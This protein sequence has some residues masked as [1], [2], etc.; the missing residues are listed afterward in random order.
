MLGAL[1]AWAAEPDFLREVRPILSQHC[2]QCHGPDENARKAGLRLDERDAALQPLKRG[3]AAIVP[4]SPDASTLVQR[5]FTSD[6]DDVMPPPSIKRPL[7]DRKKDV[8]RR[9]IA[10]GAEYQ[11][12]WA[13]APPVQVAL[14]LVKRT[15]WPRNGIDHFVLERFEQR[16]LAPSPPADR[17]VLIRRASL[18]LT[19]LPPTIAEADAFANDL[20]PDAYERLVERLLA[21]P[22][23]G[24]RWARRWMDLARYAD[25]NGFEKD[26]PRSI[27]LWR[28]WLIRALNADLPFDQFTIEQLA[29]DLLPDATVD[30]RVAT[31]FHRNTMLNEEGGIDP[32]EYRFY[33]VVDRLNTTGTTW[34]GLT[35]GCAQ[36]HTHKYDPVTQR[37]YYAMMAFLNN[38]DEPV[39]AVPTAPIT[40][41]RT[42]LEARIA[43][44]EAELPAR[45]P[46]ELRW[47]WETPTPTVTTADGIAARVSPD[48]SVWVEQPTSEKNTY[49]LTLDT[50]LTNFT[51]LRLEVLPDD[52]LPRRGPG[53][54]ESGNFVLSELEVFAAPPDASAEP[55]L[56]ELVS[57]EADYS[58]SGFGVARAIDGKRDSGWAIAGSGDWNVQRTASFG[59]KQ[60]LHQPSGT[61]VTVRLVQEFGGRHVLGR[62]RLSLAEELPDPRPI[63]VRRLEH[64]DRQFMAWVERERPRAA[65]W[66][67]LRPL[68]AR[69]SVPV[70]SI[71][72]DGGV[73]VTSD[74]TKSDTYDLTYRTEFEGITALR[75]EVLPDDRLPQ[76][77]PGRVEY[78]GPV[79]DFFLS[80]FALTVNGEPVRF[81]RATSS[82][83]KDGQQDAAKAVDDD[84]QS[85]WSVDG[86]QGRRHTAVFTLAAPLTTADELTVRMLFEKYYAAGLG[87]FRL[88]ATTQSGG[89]EASALPDDLLA[90]VARSPATWTEPERT[91]L[92]AYYC[93]VAPELAA[94]REPIEKLRREMPAY[95]TTLVMRERPPENP[96]ATFVHHRGEFLQPRERVEPGIPSVL[97]GLPPDAPRNR[98]GFARWLVSRENPLTARVVVNR[99]WAAFFGRGLVATLGDFGFQGELPSHPE[100]LDWLAVEFMNQ[101]WSLKGLHRLIMTSATYRQAATVTPRLLELDPENQWLARAPRLRLDAEQVRDTALLAAGLLSGKLGGPSVFPPQI[102]SITKEGTYGP[103]DWKVSVGEDRYRRGLYT[104]AKRTAPYA[105]F[106]TFDGPS[107]ETCVA[108]REVSNTPLQALTLLNDQVFHEAAQVLGRTTAAQP[109]GDRERAAFVLRRCLTRTPDAG[110]LEQVVQFY[111]AQ[112][113]RLA[114]GELAAAELAGSTEGDAVAAA[115]WTAVARVVL[116][117]DEMVTRN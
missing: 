2:F 107:G 95:P 16:G 8:L 14:P 68:T 4:G 106:L 67:L 98:L 3:R 52:R 39:L 103:L 26:R 41:R 116:N 87:R 90:L 30:Q 37:E 104:F 60:P 51:R 18:D 96:R 9:W 56:L 79:G 48:G 66:T 80:T 94:E 63:E 10:A 44:L 34:L 47:R 99:E 83:A 36:C 12:H 15:D 91:R 27:W 7:N 114:R 62:F 38:A 29:G 53:W 50:G 89:T 5:V 46:P 35:V 40:A 55:Q 100:L 59:V 61:R 71:E 75:L 22:H 57:P 86:G 108:R 82:Y 49:T 13:F 72:A 64:R 105:A 32:L 20:A 85:G 23:Y 54:S 78:E 112:R 31:G 11:P 84:P 1:G 109:G 65:T 58:Q 19:G 110:E 17:H 77:G 97:P 113:E 93:R 42:E 24:E 76:R 92:L 70:L 25:T 33:S 6:E 74:Q 102:E 117:L 69:G 21:S 111:R 81:A 28:D 88:W 43:A 115:A 101:G 45:F 73:F